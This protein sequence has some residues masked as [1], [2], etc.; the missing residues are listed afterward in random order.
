MWFSL[1]RVSPLSRLRPDPT[2]SFRRSLRSFQEVSPGPAPASTRTEAP[3]PRLPVRGSSPTGWGVRRSR[4]KSPSG[5][6]RARIPPS[7]QIR[8]YRLPWRP[9]P[10]TS[11]FSRVFRRSRRVESGA[12]L[13]GE[14]REFACDTES[15]GGV[16]SVPSTGKHPLTLGQKR[17][18]KVSV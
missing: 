4:N 12:V 14:R 13:G 10:S 5:T 18:F 2:S 7:R 16:S 8:V 1:G 15:G 3:S 6:R 17:R 11:C 9:G